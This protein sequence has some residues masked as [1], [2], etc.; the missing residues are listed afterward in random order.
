MYRL[1]PRVLQY[2][3]RHNGGDLDQ[4]INKRLERSTISWRY[5][6]RMRS[7]SCQECRLVPRVLQHQVRHNGGDLEHEL[8][9]GSISWRIRIRMRYVLSMP[10]VHQKQCCGSGSVCSGA[11]RFLPSRANKVRK[12]LISTILWLLFDFLS[13]Q[14]HVNVPSKS[15]KLKCWKIIYFLLASCQPLTKKKANSGCGSVSQWYISADPDQDQYKNVTD[16]QHYSE[17]TK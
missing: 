3:G 9:R 1:V 16:P 5:R 2:Q 6:I 15:N 8:K 14:T 10:G 17:N 4:K 7:R 13:M 11:S 12:N